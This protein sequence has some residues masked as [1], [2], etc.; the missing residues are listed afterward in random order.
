MYAWARKNIVTAKFPT[1][2][3][4]TRGQDFNLGQ[5]LVELANN[6]VFFREF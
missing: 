4:P 1:N 5:D 6:R 2:L 3:Q